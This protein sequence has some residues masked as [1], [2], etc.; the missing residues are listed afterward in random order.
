MTTKRKRA[1]KPPTARNER[2]SARVA[3]TAAEIISWK[4]PSDAILVH[5][6]TLP[7]GNFAWT[8]GAL[9]LRALAMFAL[10]HTKDRAP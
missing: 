8:V 4:I 10:A 6:R 9:D 1:T 7:D 3:K 2:P 5:G